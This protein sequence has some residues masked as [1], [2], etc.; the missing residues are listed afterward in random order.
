MKRIALMFLT[1]VVIAA[2]APRAQD[3]D[4]L[5]KAAMNTEL[6]DGNLQAAIEQYKKVVQ[7]GSRALAAQALLRIGFGD[8]RIQ[9]GD[10]G[11][12]RRQLHHDIAAIAVFL[13]HALDAAHLALD[14]AQAQQHFGLRAFANWARC[15]DFFHSHDL[16]NH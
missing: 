2:A 8:Q 3:V 1:L 11:L 10:R 16:Y 12:D 9:A 4:K 6:V 5:F 14:P 15:F 7:T 13:N